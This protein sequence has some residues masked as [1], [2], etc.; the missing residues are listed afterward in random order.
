[1]CC[2]VVGVVVVV[3]VVVLVVNVGVVVAFGAPRA[4]KW[5]HSLGAE[6]KNT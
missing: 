2:V 1:M 5:A 6:K 3:N 4:R